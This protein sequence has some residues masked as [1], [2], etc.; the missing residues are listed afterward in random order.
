MNEIISLLTILILIIILG[1]VLMIWI[2]KYKHSKFSK[3]DIKKFIRYYEQIRREKDYKHAILDADKLLDEILFK[4][5]YQGSLGEK[6]KQ[7]KRLFSN[8]DDVWIAHKIR[9]K[10]AHEMSYKPSKSEYQKAMTSFKKAYK[11]LGIL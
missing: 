1:V 10:I 4:K 5:G 6:L 3:K 2:Q 7:S 11:D 8:I 9:N